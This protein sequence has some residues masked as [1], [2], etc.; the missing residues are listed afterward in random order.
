MQWTP[1][2]TILL[3]EV[4]RERLWAVRPMTVVQDEDDL[5]V[6]W[7]P[8]GAIR[9]VPTNPPTRQRLP[10]R[11]ER[12]AASLT[13]LDWVHVDNEWDVDTLW[14]MREGDWHATWV[15]YKDDAHWGWYINLQEPFRR[16]R[17][18]VQTMDLEL[19]VIIWP[20]RT[21]YY[22]DEDEF[23]Y[24]V[25]HGLI[26]ETKAKHARDEALRVIGRAQADEPP[27]SEDWGEWKPDPSWGLPVLPDDWDSLSDK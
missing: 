8:K 23:E 7:H 25:A 9:K 2:E 5:V 15:A 26:D 27:F 4:Y 21:W 6:L 20:D 1:G 14:L 16:T 24:L 17:R 22:K 12:F 19:D 10:T 13:L 18:G 3:Q 11:A